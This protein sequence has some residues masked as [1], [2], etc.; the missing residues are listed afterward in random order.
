MK[1][2]IPVDELTRLAFIYGEQ[3]RRSYAESYPRDATEYILAK[4]EA[5]QMHAYR[6]KRWGLTQL[7]ADIA[8]ATTVDVSDLLKRNAESTR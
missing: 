8:T 5:N 1:T 3:D 6:V 7:E 4:N 2:R